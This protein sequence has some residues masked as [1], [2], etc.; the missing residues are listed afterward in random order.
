M[1]TSPSIPELDYFETYYI[2]F[3]DIFSKQILLLIYMTLLASR[4][5][6][7]CSVVTIF[8]HIYE[9]ISQTTHPNKAKF[10][11]W[12]F[13]EKYAASCSYILSNY[14]CGASAKHQV[15]FGKPKHIP[16]HRE[17]KGVRGWGEGK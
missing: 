4:K 8:L 11:H 15:C 9:D 10:L 14:V 5:L 16:L 1:P 3:K 2:A 13:R 6:K 17:G 12:E 7:K